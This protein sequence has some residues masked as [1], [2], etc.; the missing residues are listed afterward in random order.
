MSGKETD[1]FE[2]VAT[3]LPRVTLENRPKGNERTRWVSRRIKSNCPRIEEKNK[4]ELNE[5][6]DE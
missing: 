6:S 4:Q 3:L 1:I 2:I 5:T